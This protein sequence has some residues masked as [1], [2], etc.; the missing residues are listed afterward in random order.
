MGSKRQNPGIFRTSRGHQGKEGECEI[1]Q[2]LE[3]KRPLLMTE[4]G[5]GFRR[6]PQSLV[7][8]MFPT[9]LGVLRLLGLRGC[10]WEAPGAAVDE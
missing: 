2:C 8:M 3:M 5:G 9:R 10:L 4:L 1:R 7:L 6:W